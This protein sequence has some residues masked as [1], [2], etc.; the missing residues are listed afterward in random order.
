MNSTDKIKSV[1]SRLMTIKLL[2][3]YIMLLLIFIFWI[4]I[5]NQFVLVVAALFV[6]IL[7]IIY[8]LV[9]VI[10]LLFRKFKLSLYFIVPVLLATMLGTLPIDLVLPIDTWPV[11]NKMIH[12]RHYVEYVIQR[13]VVHPEM[14]YMTDNSPYSEWVIHADFSDDYKIIFDPTDRILN[15]DD[16]VI[17][18]RSIHVYSL[19]NHFYMYVRQ[20]LG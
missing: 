14:K 5:Y 6:L 8:I 11:R 1:F 17:K 4:W 19:G 16:K 12:A 10:L 7:S 18:D 13:N 15:D 9:V 2:P 3:T 20:Y